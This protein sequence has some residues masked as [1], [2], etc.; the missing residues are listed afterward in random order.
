V[1][2]APPAD[3]V[4]FWPKADFVAGDENVRFQEHSGPGAGLSRMSAP[5]P[6]RTRITRFF[7]NVSFGASGFTGKMPAPMGGGREFVWGL[8]GS[9]A[10]PLTAPGQLQ[11]L[12]RRVGALSNFA[13]SDPEF[14][15]SP[16]ARST[17]S[18]RMSR[19]R[20]CFCARVSS[21]AWRRIPD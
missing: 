7:A 1:D 18:R 14:T 17:G 9:L 6:E 3:D 19:G 2:I 11:E 16:P 20:A 10:W 4:R 5:D 21:L 15:Q 12:M 8:A 13:E